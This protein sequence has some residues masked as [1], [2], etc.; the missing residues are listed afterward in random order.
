MLQ[1][2]DIAVAPTA[3][4][5]RL[6]LDQRKCRLHNNVPTLI[7]S[8]H[9]KLL[10]RRSLKRDLEKQRLLEL[11]L[12][13]L[14]LPYSASPGPTSTAS[15]SNTSSTGNTIPFRRSNTPRNT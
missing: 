12:T 11:T 4:A 14:S 13:N 2:S 7:T 5:L 8:V 9:C 10:K 3:K 15:L 1:R 6:K